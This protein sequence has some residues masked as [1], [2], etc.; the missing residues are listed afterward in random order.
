M[1]QLSVIK[2][3]IEKLGQ[4]EGELGAARR[5]FQNNRVEYDIIDSQFEVIGDAKVILERLLSR[6]EIEASKEWKKESL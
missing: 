5:A 6:V 1:S 4:V 2:G 3:I